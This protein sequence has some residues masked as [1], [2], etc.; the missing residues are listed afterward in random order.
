M[1]LN[2]SNLKTLS[3]EHDIYLPWISSLLQ[4][5]TK[6]PGATQQTSEIISCLSLGT[7]FLKFY[8]GMQQNILDS[9]RGSFNWIQ[10]YLKV[11][12]A[13]DF[14]NRGTF[15]K[16]YPIGPRFSP[17]LQFFQIWSWFCGDM[18]KNC[19]TFQGC[20]RRK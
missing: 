17:Y 10:L 8:I 14:W 4:F 7:Y 9:A 16:R 19:F 15:I 1:F 2:P 13:Q 3:L 5:Q 11:T 20:A 12:A 6:K 18:R